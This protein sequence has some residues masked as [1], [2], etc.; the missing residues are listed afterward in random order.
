MTGLDIGSAIA[1]RTI[2][3]GGIALIVLAVVML[4]CGLLNKKRSDK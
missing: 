2:G 3:I 4:A 1:W